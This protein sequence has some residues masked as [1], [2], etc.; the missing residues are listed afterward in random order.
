MIGVEPTLNVALEKDFWCTRNYKD[1]SGYRIITG[2][3]P[4]F[5]Q[6]IT[7]LSLFFHFL[8]SEK[9][10]NSFFGYHNVLMKTKYVQH[11]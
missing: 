8:L 4:N 10:G 2:M 11:C 9:T 3:H 1:S 6:C 7:A 5:S